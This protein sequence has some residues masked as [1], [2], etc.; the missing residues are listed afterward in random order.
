MTAEPVDAVLKV[1]RCC[2][3]AHDAEKWQALHLVGI[4]E[5]EPDLEL[6][7]CLCG[8]TLALEV[9]AEARAA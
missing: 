5:S 7:N 3:R 9:A 4:Q 6:R 8:S 1:C 2:G